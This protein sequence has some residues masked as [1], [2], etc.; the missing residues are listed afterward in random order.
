MSKLAAVDTA[1]R[2]QLAT[3][4][5]TITYQQNM[6]VANTGY[7][8]DDGIERFLLGVAN[9]LK[10]DTPSYLFDWSILDA[11]RV[12]QKNLLIVLSLIDEKTNLADTEK[13]KP[14][15]SK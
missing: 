13:I 12:R 5:K 8:T 15:E 7:D 2:L 10:L 1:I 14:V 9:R 3:D 11:A 6:N 4:G